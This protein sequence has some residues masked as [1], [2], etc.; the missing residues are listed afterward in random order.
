M[1]QFIKTKRTLNSLAACR[2]RVLN[3][4]PINMTI[5]TN[6]ENG[7]GLRKTAALF[8]PSERRGRR[9]PRCVA[10]RA[11][12][13]VGANVVKDLSFLPSP[14]VITF[15]RRVEV[16]V[17]V[18]AC[19][20]GLMSSSK[21]QPEKQQSGTAPKKTQSSTTTESGQ[22]GPP[23]NQQPPPDRQSKP[24]DKQQAAAPAKRQTSWD[25]PRPSSA[26]QQLP[27][28]KQRSEIRR[29]P[30]PLPFQYQ[31]EQHASSG[32][33]RPESPTMSRA[34]SPASFVEIETEPAPAQ[35]STVPGSSQMS[36][37]SE[38]ALSCETVEVTPLRTP[39]KTISHE[40]LVSMAETNRNWPGPSP[41]PHGSYRHRCRYE[42]VH[43]GQYGVVYARP[44]NWQ[45]TRAPLGWSRAEG[46]SERTGG[47][48]NYR[49][50]YS[51]LRSKNEACMVCPSRWDGTL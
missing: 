1:Q 3:W 9:P 24:P 40:Q 32:N 29:D 19:R 2:G 44:K 39:T 14:S 33:V 50:G 25:V 21:G 8:F 43:T 7:G 41:L 34:F 46:G 18:V 26:R 27:P 37:P 13:T 12:T 20:Y 35:S 6:P 47:I 15:A 4:M 23:G 42:C 16:H 31:Q 11:A 38:I 28:E 5:I 48:V 22:H 51:R 36:P 10:G 17:R 49:Q 30:P 45:G